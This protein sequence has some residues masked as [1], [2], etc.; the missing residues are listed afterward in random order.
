[1]CNTDVALD[2]PSLHAQAVRDGR[3]SKGRP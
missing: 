1:V 3:D 2:C